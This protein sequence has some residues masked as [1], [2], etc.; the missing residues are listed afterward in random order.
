[1][2]QYHATSIQQPYMSAHPF[3][4]YQT[5]VPLS[6]P[7][8]TTSMPSPASGHPLPRPLSNLTFPLDAT[9]YYLLGQLEYY[10]SAQNLISDIF[11]RKRVNEVLGPFGMAVLYFSLTVAC[12]DGRWIHGGGYRFRCLRRSIGFVS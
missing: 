7:S 11:L 6:Y 2:G 5:P 3:E 1:V 9:R 10:L 8:P 4:A 12:A